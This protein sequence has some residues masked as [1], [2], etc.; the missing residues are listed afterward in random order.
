MLGEGED[1]TPFATAAVVSSGSVMFVAISSSG[2][3]CVCREGNFSCLGKASVCE[4]LTVEFGAGLPFSSPGIALASNIGNK[5]RLDELH[6]EGEEGAEERCD[7]SQKDHSGD[8]CSPIFLV[9][10][11]LLARYVTPRACESR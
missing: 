3:G 6:R 8:E 10:R 11:G 1:R 9:R 5:S 2:M 4:G 7:G